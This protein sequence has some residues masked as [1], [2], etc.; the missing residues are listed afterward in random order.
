MTFTRNAYDAIIE[1]LDNFAESNDV[2]EKGTNLQAARSGDAAAH[3]EVSWCALGGV[4]PETAEEYAFKICQAAELCR[5]LNREQL[6]VDPEAPEG[7]KDAQ[8]YEGFV[9][10]YTEQFAA[11]PADPFN[12]DDE[13]EEEA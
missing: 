8:T 5:T 12:S 6:R 7:I 1:A 2:R 9:D 10:Y 13:E 4:D 3:F 11:D